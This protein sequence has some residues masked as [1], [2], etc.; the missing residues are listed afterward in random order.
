M[1]LLCKGKIPFIY[2]HAK[3]FLEIRSAAI[4][5]RAKTGFATSEMCIQ[6]PLY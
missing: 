2:W 1:Q 5:V 4:N 3:S 6:P